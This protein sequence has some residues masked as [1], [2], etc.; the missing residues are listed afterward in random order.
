METSYLKG[1]VGCCSDCCRMIGA[2]VGSTTSGFSFVPFVQVV[3]CCEVLHNQLIV[4]L[5]LNLSRSN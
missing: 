5:D 2:G 3:A 1:S 4:K